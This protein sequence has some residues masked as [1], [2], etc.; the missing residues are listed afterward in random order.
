MNYKTIHYLCFYSE[1]DR[2]YVHFPSGWTKIEYISSILEDKFRI[3]IV[4]PVGKKSLDLLPAIF[5]EISKNVSLIHFHTF[6]FKCLEKFDVLFRWIQLFYYLITK[7]KNDDILLIYHSMFYVDVINMYRK[8]RKLN[9]IVFQLEELYYTLSKENFA[10][11]NKELSYVNSFKKM[12]VVSDLLRDRFYSDEK[13][14]I[15]AYG[16]Y[17]FVNLSPPAKHQDK[18]II[19][20]AG[21]IEQDRKA[22][23]YAVEA[24]K[25]LPNNYTLN[26]AGFGS[27]TD[28]E[29]LKIKIDELNHLFLT[30]K[31]TFLGYLSGETYKT[32]LLS[33]D[34]GLSCHVYTPDE[35]I[36]AE[37][38]FSSKLIVYLK[39][40]L[41]VVSNNIQCVKSSALADNIIFFEGSD[42]K[43]IAN[44]I[45][46]VENI[47]EN[48]KLIQSLDLK[49]RNQLPKLFDCIENE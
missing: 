25:Y 19:I 8:I 10:F 14:I 21:I 44:A 13:N 3:Q 20:Y 2:D 17:R 27:E 33:A 47:K 24:M 11:K 48:Y 26:I 23:F 5:K 1:I 30:E 18:T 38:T 22:A 15:V 35:L 31:A 45:L 41:N 12:I 43:S 7:V 34:V 36:S 29:K 39:H 42:P 16:D 46:R 32:A 49:F 40:N 9:N 28:I 6:R 37:N 4:S